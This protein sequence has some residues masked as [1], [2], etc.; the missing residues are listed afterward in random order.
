MHRSRV[1]LA[2]LALAG[3][4]LF[5]AACGDDDDTD[6]PATE[7][8]SEE[9]MSEDTMMDDEEMSEDTTMDDEEMED[10][11]ATTAP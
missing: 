6:V 9:E 3:G 7:A 8:P 10:E 4:S 11:S 1:A 5:V 2:A